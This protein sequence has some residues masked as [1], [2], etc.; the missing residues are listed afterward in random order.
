MSAKQQLIEIIKKELSMITKSVYPYLFE[1]LQSQEGK[2]KV[3]EM[4]FD[5]AVKN[6]ISVSAAIVQLENEFEL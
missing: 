5:Y 2:E 3:V 1:Q 4:I 6:Q